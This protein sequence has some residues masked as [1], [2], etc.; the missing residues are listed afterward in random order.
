MSLF[1]Y[2]SKK[3]P[4]EKGNS[5]G[6]RGVDEDEVSVSVPVHDE[7]PNKLLDKDSSPKLNDNANAPDPNMKK[8][9]DQKYLDPDD[10]SPS[11]PIAVPSNALE[12]DKRI[13]R[14][15]YQPRNIR[16]PHTTFGERTRAF[17][18][19]WY[20]KYSWI[21]YSKC[22]RV[23]CFYCRFFG[24]NMSESST[25][26]FVNQGFQNYYRADESFKKHAT[27]NFHHRCMKS[28]EDYVSKCKPINALLDD[29]AEQEMARK[30]QLRLANREYMQ[31][32]IDITILLAKGGRSFRGHDESDES[33]SK[34]LF[35]DLYGLLTKYDPVFQTHVQNLPGNVNYSS[36]TSQNELIES[37]HNVMFR[38]IVKSLCGK[39]V[40]LMADETTDLGH[41]EQFSVIVRFFDDE[42]G[43][44]TETYTSIRKLDHVDAESIFK[45]LDSVVNELE[46]E[47]SD[48]IAVCFDGASTMS[49]Y[50]SGVQARCKEKNPNILY[51]HCYAH[52][53]N[54]VLVDAC[55]SDMQDSKISNFFGTIQ[56]L[57]AFIEG[58]G[59]R[60]AT[61]ESIGKTLNVKLKSLKS[62][63]TTRWACR[64][65]AVTAVQQDY[66]AILCALEEIKKTT[67]QNEIRAKASGILKQMKTFHFIFFFWK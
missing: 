8:K 38:S 40:S 67:R 4:V 22:D 51:V 10:P 45:E 2:F 26:A 46:L 17:N 34:G 32:L 33:V 52:C 56:C 5:S 64:A 28:Y 60:H 14:G 29:A 20:T 3:K 50:L 41:Y 65:E 57:F 62:L 30:E 6:V 25:S 24:T 21:E 47:W 61:F 42:S 55:T 58:S 43:G 54:L 16:F 27:S 44:P 15:P 53:L 63:S 11:N 35:R 66:D 49:G 31:R 23:F 1:R 13:R 12:R 37:L 7:Q 19:N 9:I 36:A 39:K 18:P 59:V 48:V